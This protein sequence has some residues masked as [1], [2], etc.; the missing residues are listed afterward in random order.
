MA[1]SLK[2]GNADYEIIAGPAFLEGC[3]GVC[4]VITY[5]EPALSSFCGFVSGSTHHWF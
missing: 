3:G 1:K 2:H 4:V 5:I